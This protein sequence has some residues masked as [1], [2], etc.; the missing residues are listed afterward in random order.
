MYKFP[1]DGGTRHT[2]S[3]IDKYFAFDDF[4]LLHT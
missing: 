4:D 2:Y 1:D 3:V